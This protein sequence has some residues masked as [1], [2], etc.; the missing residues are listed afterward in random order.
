M[1]VKLPADEN[2][3]IQTVNGY[4]FPLGVMGGHYSN[5]TQW[6]V[7]NFLM[8]SYHPLHFWKRLDRLCFW[9][10]AYFFWPFFRFHVRF[11]LHREAL[12]PHLQRELDQGRYLSLAL[13]EYF[14]PGK[15]SYQKRN[16]L[17]DKHLY[18]Y[19]DE[20][21][22]FYALSIADKGMFKRHEI[23]YEDL[24]QAFRF[25][26]WNH[27]Y[28]AFGL[29]PYDFTR[30]DPGKIDRQL[31]RYLKNRKNQGI[32]CYDLIIRHLETRHPG[33]AVNML[34]IRMFK[35]HKDLLALLDPSFSPIKKQFDALF[36][37]CIKYNLTGDAAILERQIPKLRR[38]KEQERALIAAY[39]SRRGS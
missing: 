24:C 18:G 38:M 4:A 6:V 22:V 15:S 25:Y 37:W 36:Y 39:R 13:N 7:H 31:R 17:H 28:L 3:L 23:R 12:V 14:I 8:I 11:L 33:E 30:A 34:I 1:I 10:P 27:F 21:G 16:F 26:R 2:P 19:N 29:K 9:K 32:N 20:A 35:E 5:S